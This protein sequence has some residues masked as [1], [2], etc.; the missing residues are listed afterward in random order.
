MEILLPRATDIV[1]V[2]WVKVDISRGRLD[3]FAGNWKIVIPQ[4]SQTQ[5]ELGEFTASYGWQDNTSFSF[6]H[7]T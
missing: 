4:V 6:H 1:A 5:R 7:E 2:G 3:F